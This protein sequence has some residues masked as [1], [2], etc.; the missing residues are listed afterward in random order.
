MI[1]STEN[2]TML[3][4][5][6]PK[7]RLGPLPLFEISVTLH[8]ASGVNSYSMEWIKKYLTLCLQTTSIADLIRTAPTLDLEYRDLFENYNFRRINY[9]RKHECLL[10]QMQKVWK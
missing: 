1:M 3:S 6:A 8:A 10:K 7:K 9:D 2:Q 5:Y 4:N